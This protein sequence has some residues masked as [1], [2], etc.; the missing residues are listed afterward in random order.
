MDPLILFINGGIAVLQSAICIFYSCRMN[1]KIDRLEHN[2]RMLVKNIKLRIERLNYQ[3]PPEIYSA[4]P[5]PSA[6][7]LFSVYP[8][9]HP[10]LHLYPDV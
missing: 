9:S 6:P 8:E 4:A 1:D 7:D 5:K 2:M 10:K 3:P